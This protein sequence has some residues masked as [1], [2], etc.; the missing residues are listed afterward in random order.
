MA[1]L[2]YMDSALAHLAKRNFAPLHVFDVGASNGSWSIKASGYFGSAQFH[3]FDPLLENEPAL[4]LLCERDTRFH[5]RLTALGAEPGEVQMNVTPD[6]DASSLLRWDGEDPARRRT[7]PV[8][9]LDQLMDRG[10]LP[11]PGLV[12]IDVQGF[13]LEVL[14][15]ARRALETAEVFIVEVNLYEF[16]HKCPRVHDVVAFFAERRYYLFDIAGMLRRPFDENLAQMD[17]VF[18]SASSPLANSSRWN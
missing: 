15:G 6:H 17:L 1:G 5:Y 11:E 7:I 2:D 16:M 18:A 9:T 8:A 14:K 10:D 3:L 4:K 13:E 12:K